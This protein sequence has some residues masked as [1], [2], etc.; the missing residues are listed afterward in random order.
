[1]NADGETSDHAAECPVSYTVVDGGTSGGKDDFDEQ[2]CDLN[3]GVQMSTRVDG[4][5]SGMVNMHAVGPRRKSEK[6]KEILTVGDDEGQVGGK[7]MLM[8]RR[9]TCLQGG[10]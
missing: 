4:G 6:F 9:V 8:S 2:T 3:A 7:M 1:M 5:T 10:Q